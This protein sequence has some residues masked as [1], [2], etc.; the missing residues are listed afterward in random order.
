M[1]MD[2]YGIKPVNDT[3]TYFR[4]NIWYWRPLWSY[5]VNNYGDLLDDDCAEGFNN[6]GYTVSEDQAM[7]LGLLILA[8]I[9][10][11]K[12]KQYEIDYEE[13]KQ[14]RHL[15]P[16]QYCAATG[17]RTDDVGQRCN[18][19]TQPL[20]PD[21][22]EELGRTHGTCNGCSGRGYREPFENSYY[23]ETKNMEEFA[24]FALCSGGFTIC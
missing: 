1:G 7:K 2:V 18:F 3:G 10:H 5:V 8:D 23:F 11:G 14:E 15:E 21:L 13:A 24:H 4:N 20:R 12:I 22:A 9:A 17:I 6:S 19:P 16:C